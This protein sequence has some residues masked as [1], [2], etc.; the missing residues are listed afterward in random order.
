MEID[1][2]DLQR[3]YR[4]YVMEKIPLTRK[5]CP[6]TKDIIN[7]FKAKLSEKRKTEIVDHITNCCYCLQEFDFILQTLRSE[8]TLSEEIGNLIQSK[9]E[10]SIEEQRKRIF[11]FFRKIWNAFPP[12][13]S[14]KYALYFIGIVVIVL[15]FVVLSE[16]YYFKQLRKQEERGKGILSVNLIEPTKG[17]YARSRLVFK[18]NEIRD[19]DYYLLELF[20][21]TLLP[22][23]K[24][25][26]LFKSQFILPNEIAEKLVS[27]KTYFWAI[28]VYFP[29]G[30]LLESKIEEFSL[31]D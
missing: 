24:S 23:W 18:W 11:P 28:T 27:N 9:K 4:E 1:D 16:K 22:V 8:K 13:L 2:K 25:S 15:G 7:F 30:K 5:N 14:W 6:P 29:D 31:K 17:V 10:T 26:K 19:C 12:H 21:E 20:D 3:L